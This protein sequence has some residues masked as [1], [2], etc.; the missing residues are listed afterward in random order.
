VGISPNA[1]GNK[2]E[3][4][5]FQGQRSASQWSNK[6]CRRHFLTCLGNVWSYETYYNHSLLGPHDTD[7]ILKVI[8]SKFKVTEVI[9]NIF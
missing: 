1:V 3:L 7:S 5:R 2:G 4:I 6:H 9:D 8:G